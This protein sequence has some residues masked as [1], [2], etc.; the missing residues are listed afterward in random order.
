[1]VK[2][3]D[4]SKASSDSAATELEKKLNNFTDVEGLSTRGLTFGVWYMK[5]RRNFFLIAVW[6][7]TIIAT[8][9][10]VYSL[11]YFGYY[12]LVGSKT[13]RLNESIISDNPRAV[14]QRKLLSSLSYGFVQSVDL[15]RNSYSLIGK[16]ASAN[17]SNWSIFDYYFLVDGEPMG[18]S[19]SYILPNDEKYLTSVIDGL[20]TQPDSVQLIVTNFRW[21]RIDYHK[22]S[23]WP[24]YKSDRLSF[25]VLDKKFVGA[26]ESSLSDRLPVNSL[27]FNI[28][29]RTAYSFREASLQVILYSGSEVVYVK[30]YIINNFYSKERRDINLT[31][32]GSLP[33]I[34]RVE[35]L[36]E[37][38]I[39]DQNVYL[40]N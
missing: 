8:V 31:L 16:L 17:K 15:G 36:P 6:F 30:D 24:D 5:H 39:L 18:T 7:L 28:T 22:I 11:Y 13:D 35:V 19:T 3:I 20:P 23:S 26:N 2:S 32:I 34:T 1:M 10:W 38:N 29:N 21:S 4:N 40:K 9:L 27:S 25:L 14:E 37:I 12:L 33:N